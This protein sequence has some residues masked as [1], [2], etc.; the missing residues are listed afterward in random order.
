MNYCQVI[1][2]VQFMVANLIMDKTVN[3]FWVVIT[4]VEC[5]NRFESTNGVTAAKWT[6]PQCMML[7]RQVS[8]P[9]RDK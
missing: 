9:T 6:L 2:C 3:V 4:E 8:L 7:C 1:P 5:Q